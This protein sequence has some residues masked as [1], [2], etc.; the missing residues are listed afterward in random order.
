MAMTSAVPAM[1]AVVGGALIGG[2][3]YWGISRFR[4]G[5]GRD[6]EDLEKPA[7]R[8]AF[9]IGRV[10]VEYANYFLYIVFD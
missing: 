8:S 2:L 3:A 6:I 5:R 7:P 10:T 1:L 4:E 9:W